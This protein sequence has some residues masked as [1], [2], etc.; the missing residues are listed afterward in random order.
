LQPFKNLSGT[1]SWRVSGVLHG[2]RVRRNFRDRGDALAEKR[3]LE[4]RA[5]QAASGMREVGT[6]LTDT[7]LREAEAAFLRL[8]EL[9]ANQAQPTQPHQQQT[10]SLTFYLDYA[11][12]H[13]KEPVA[14]KPLAEAIGEYVA[15]RE[16]DCKREQISEIQLYTIKN[17][18]RRLTVFFPG[19][20]VA[21]LSAERI[22]QFCESG[23]GKAV[24]SGV[25]GDL[26]E[27]K[28]AGRTKK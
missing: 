23:T 14:W 13:Y 4:L 6:F 8:R 2:E 19:I 9:A 5:L 15:R 1:V 21:D 27:A 22:I 20:A 12:R 16:A 25:A 10:R 7:Q 3:A 17:H 26:S 24:K 11:L 28:N 18:M